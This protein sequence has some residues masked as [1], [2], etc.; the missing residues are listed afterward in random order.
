MLFYL[1]KWFLMLY[2]FSILVGYLRES[3][4]KRGKNDKRVCLELSFQME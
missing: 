3:T 2:N 4:F 1:T